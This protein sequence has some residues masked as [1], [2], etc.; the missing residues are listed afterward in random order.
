MIQA[1]AAPPPGRNGWV[2]RLRRWLLV[3]IAL[4]AAGL[5]TGSLGLLMIGHLMSEE[6]LTPIRAEAMLS[7]RPLTRM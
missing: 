1:T 7:L 4:C 2:A 3:C 6:W 5:A